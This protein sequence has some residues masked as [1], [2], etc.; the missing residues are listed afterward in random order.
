MNNYQILIFNKK[1]DTIKKKRKYML[2]VI[3]IFFIFK[4][5]THPFVIP[6]GTNHLKE[7]LRN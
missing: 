1:I 2:F 3:S 5:Q 7:W 4:G 6:L